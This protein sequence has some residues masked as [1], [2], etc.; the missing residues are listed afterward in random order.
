MKNFLVAVS[1]ILVA[2]LFGGSDPEG[3]MFMAGF[4]GG[5]KKKKQLFPR[6]P[7]QDEAGVKHEGE[8]DL[9]SATSV[10]TIAD[11]ICEGEIEGLVS[12]E[13]RFAGEENNIGYTDSKF[14]AY[15]RKRELHDRVRLS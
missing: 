8:T 9:Y 11:L 4:F 10:V 6:P 5:S 15:T 12:G 1:I 7:I 14:N 13:Y 3:I 2:Y